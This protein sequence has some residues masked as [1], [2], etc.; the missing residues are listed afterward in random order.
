[1]YSPFFGFSRETHL[2]YSS[3]FEIK[4]ER[5][6]PSFLRFINLF[7]NRRVLGVGFRL[8]V[9]MFVLSKHERFGF[10]LLLLSLAF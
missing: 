9:T 5:H 4:T 2:A 1:M 7:F 10:F 8:G 6:C 3:N